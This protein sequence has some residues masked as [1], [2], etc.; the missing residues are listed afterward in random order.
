MPPKSM[1][2]VSRTLDD[3]VD[4]TGNVRVWPAS[5]TLAYCIVKHP[6]LF[7]CRSACEVRWV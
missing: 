3:P 7:R 5:E 4:N 6:E 2:E 1:I